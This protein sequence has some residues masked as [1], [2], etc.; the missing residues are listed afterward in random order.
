MILNIP[1]N[2]ILYYFFLKHTHTQ[3][4]ERKKKRKTKKKKKKK[5]VNLFFNPDVLAVGLAQKIRDCRC[6]HT[7]ISIVHLYILNIEY[8]KLSELCE[9]SHK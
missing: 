2:K 8:H 7:D 1:Q 6:C 9:T 3:K 5:T 4:K